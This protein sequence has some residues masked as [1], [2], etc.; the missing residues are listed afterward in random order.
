[1]SNGSDREVYERVEGRR[2]NQVEAL[3]ELLRG[4]SRG[5][6]WELAMVTK[7][8]D[9]DLASIDVDVHLW[10]GSEDNTTPAR[11]GHELA[12]RMPQAHLTVYPGEGHQCVFLHWREMLQ[13]LT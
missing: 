13:A 4:G 2:D 6:A 3:E 5:L 7:P 8:W 1:M 11:I 10:Y 9:I 12:Q